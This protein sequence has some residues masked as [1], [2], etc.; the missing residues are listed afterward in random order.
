M[1]FPYRRTPEAATVPGRVLM[2][3]VDTTRVRLHLSIQ[4]A[5][6]GSLGII[7]GVHENGE[8]IED[9]IREELD[10]QG[11]PR[12]AGRRIF[13][14]HAMRRDVWTLAKHLA[15]YPDTIAATGNGNLLA[16]PHFVAWQDGRLYHLAGEPVSTRRYTCL[17]ARGH[18]VSIEPLTT[19]CDFATYGQHIVRGGEPVTREQLVAMA[20]D[21]EFYDL[22]QLLLFPR[23]SRGPERWIDPGVDS[24]DVAAALRGEPLTIDVAAFSER[25]V[26][27]ALAAKGYSDFQLRG[28]FLT[29][30]P[31]PGIYPHHLVGIRRDGS[32]FAV[33]VA[34]LSN[35]AGVTLS[36]AAEIMAGLGARDA[37]II[38]NG[39]DV[40]L[41]HHGSY[42]LE[43]RSRLRSILLCRAPDGA[44]VH[45][46]RLAV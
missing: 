15:L 41:W 17:V 3:D 28:G 9:H 31:R 22:R 46:T 5:W 42:A 10:A 29:Y 26:R 18:R 27:A 43:G 21:G 36:D 20:A 35:R 23:L 34:G 11:H 6:N 13:G 39:R 38:D 24:I 25:E 14:D 1:T 45:L 40:M 19:D 30:I 8:L 44:G 4:R 12:D 7:R 16:N 32:L 33:L 37:L 2:L